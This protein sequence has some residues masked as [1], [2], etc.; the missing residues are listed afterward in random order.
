MYAQTQT[1]RHSGSHKDDLVE[2]RQRYIE[3]QIALDKGAVNVEFA[4]RKP[5]G[6]GQANRH[7]MPSLPV[8]QHEVRN[9]PVMDLGEHP[10][11]AVEAW[12]LEVGGLLENSLTLTWRSSSCCRRPRMSAIF[13]A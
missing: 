2:R 9:W 10:D 12:K 6:T 1:S 13:I 5:A 8:G 11:I 7:G 3:R 4:G